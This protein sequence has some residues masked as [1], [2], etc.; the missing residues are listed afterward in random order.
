MKL[1]ARESGL[2]K[3]VDAI[4]WIDFMIINVPVWLFL[5][6]SLFAV[7]FAAGL[8][9]PAKLIPLA[10]A[11][12]SFCGA[13]MLA[14]DFRTR[15]RALYFRLRSRCPTGRTTPLERSLKETVCGYAVYAA[16]R[17]Y[18]CAIRA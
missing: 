13:V 17:R 11:W 2:E 7:V 1:K 10:V 12:W 3:G 8:S 5:C 14:I 15:K 4:P 9:F 6:L 16:A 18:S